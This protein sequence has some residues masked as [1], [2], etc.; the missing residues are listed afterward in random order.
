MHL[1]SLAQLSVHC[2][3][4]NNDF[5]LDLLR[6]N[7]SIGP[8]TL[9][10]HYCIMLV[11]EQSFALKKESEMNS[12]EIHTSCRSESSCNRLVV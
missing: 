12:E 7:Q 4:E 3:N 2:W 11:S 8:R 9:Q 5:R 1:H 10:E 6:Q